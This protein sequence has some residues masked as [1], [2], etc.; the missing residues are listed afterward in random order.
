MPDFFFSVFSFCVQTKNSPI[1][2]FG[3]STFGLTTRKNDIRQKQ[4]ENCEKSS[5]FVNRFKWKLR[6]RNQRQFSEKEET[7]ILK[8][9]PQTTAA[10]TSIIISSCIRV[11]LLWYSSLIQQQHQQQQQQPLTIS[12]FLSDCLHQSLLLVIL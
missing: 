1:T 2:I 10:A 9:A 5:I 11:I 7:S 4:I 3:S 6:F 8:P 12:L